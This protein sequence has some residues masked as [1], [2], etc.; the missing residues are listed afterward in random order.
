MAAGKKFPASDEM[1]IGDIS[2][3]CDVMSVF[4]VDVCEATSEIANWI[5]LMRGAL[6][7]F[8]EF[9]AKPRVAFEAMIEARIGK[10]IDA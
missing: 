1:S 8:E 3:I 4:L 5:E 6:P 10:K 2:F 9:V 7:E